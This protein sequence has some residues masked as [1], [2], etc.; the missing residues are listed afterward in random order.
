MNTETIMITI[1]IVLTIA[2][3]GGLVVVPAIDQA[4]AQGGSR[5][6]NNKLFGCGTSLFNSGSDFNGTERSGPCK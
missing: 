4:E 1:A 2:L 6:P 5:G 3:V